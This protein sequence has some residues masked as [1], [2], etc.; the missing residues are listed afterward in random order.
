M[1]AERAEV[2]AGPLCELSA[3]QLL[4]F[5]R[6]FQ[7]RAFASAAVPAVRAALGA[8][9]LPSEGHDLESSFSISSSAVPIVLISAVDQPL[10]QLLHFAEQRGQRSVGMLG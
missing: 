9:C 3:F 5:V 2:P 6:C 8:G 4:L 7:P 1:G 10:P